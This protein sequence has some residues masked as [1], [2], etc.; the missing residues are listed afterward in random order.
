MAK[1]T[2]LTFS[3]YGKDVSATNSMKKVGKQSET[4]GD[5]FKRMG[6]VAAT[7]FVGAGIAAAKFAYDAGQAAS[8]LAETQSKVGVI[9]GKNADA[10]EKFAKSAANKLGQSKQEAMDA[11]ATFA[12]FGKSAGLRG[13]ELVGFSTSLTSVTSD[14]A[15]FANTTPQEAIEAVGAALRGEAEPIRKYGVLLDEATLKNEALALG[16]VKTTAGSLTPQQKILAAQSAIYKQLGKDGSNTIG[17]FA[18]TSDG[19]ANKQRILAASFKNTKTDLGE[20]LLPMMQKFADYMLETVVPNVQGFVD[21]L[22]G[23]KN[24]GGKATKAAHNLG[25]KVK[26]VVT[27]MSEN[28]ETVANFAKVIGAIWVT[29]KINAAVTT[30]TTALGLITAAYGRLA[31]SATVAAEAQMASN[32]AGVGGAGAAGWLAKAKAGLKFLP[33]A[34]LALA[35]QGSTKDPKT[36][37]ELAK[38]RVA[39]MK[40]LKGWTDA[41]AKAWAVKQGYAGYT[42]AV[43]GSVMGRTSYLVG[44]S[45]PE[46]FTPSVSGRITPNG[47]GTGSG[48]NVTVNVQ[49]SVIQERD[50][51]VTV[52][53]Q[54]GILMRRQGLNPSIL[55]V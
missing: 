41:Q 38:R 28:Q 37:P 48:V 14:M 53:D 44:E 24:E 32:A 16:I 12:I 23:V 5:Q 10:V 6:K 15:S 19:L 8:D 29:A 13:K 40:E 49:G 25:E 47:L 9:F 18:R 27:W 26:G 4:L 7:A 45:G 54:I 21:G 43:G 33:L 20:A 55:G 52:R 36:D 50:L 22:T 35:S 42:R 17:D 39:Q 30:I 31:G 2:S 3:L 34:G 1:D 11:A 51:A 46:L